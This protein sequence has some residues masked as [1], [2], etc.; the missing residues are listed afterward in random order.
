[1]RVTVTTGARLHLGFT[2]LSGDVGRCCGSIGVALDRP[3]TTVVIDDGGAESEHTS[4]L[5]GDYV[6]RFEEH[7]G[8]TSHASVS[9][10]GGIPSH[11]GLGSGTQLALA[12][13]RGLAEV[14][15]VAATT[16]DIALAMGRC[17]RSGIG[18]ATFQGGGFVI[19]AGHRTGEGEECLRPTVVWQRDLPADW[20]FVIAI[21]DAARG[22]NGATE[23]GVFRELAP[24]V[25]ISETVCRI[26]QL[27]LMPAL[28]EEDIQQFGRAVTDIDR[29]TGE[30]F[31][32]QQG[33][34]YG[35]GGT[36]H[37]VAAMLDAGARGVGQ[38]SWGPAVYG[39]VHAREAE[40]LEATV[41]RTLEDEGVAAT[42]F[43]TRGRT[44]GASVDVDR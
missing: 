28:V 40:R 27:R 37:A 9:I 41:R 10:P 31:A 38:S 36:G 24:S 29:E 44:T 11:V 20:R 26:T 4:S 39:L 6:R 19:D 13:G 35:E 33:G 21:P 43:I 8:V 1:V 22:M 12:I 7:F 2:N 42:V 3:T 30:Y 15:G 5:V 25:R 32:A 34:V 14:C 18:A 16:W 23:E 17:R